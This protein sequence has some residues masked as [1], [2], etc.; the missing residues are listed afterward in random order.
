M[1]T[2]Y[3]VH[4]Y[5]VGKV[6]NVYTVKIHCFCVNSSPNLGVIEVKFVIVEYSKHD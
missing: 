4:E 3:S 2:L 5:T 6:W 1:C